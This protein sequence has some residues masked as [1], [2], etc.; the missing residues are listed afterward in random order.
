[1]LLTPLLCLHLAAQVPTWFQ[2][3]VVLQPDTAQVEIIQNI[4]Y[5]GRPDLHVG[6]DVYRPKAARLA[7]AVLLVHG[8]PTGSIPAEPRT[9]GQSTSLGRV[10]A[11]RGL[12]A[13]TFSHRLSTA[14]A[15]DT[16]AGDIRDAT[17]YVI[18][19][20]QTL[21][22]DASRLCVWAISAAGA[23][24]APTMREF[25]DRVRCLVSYY[26]VLSPSLLQDLVGAGERIPQTTP[27]LSDLMS[28]DSLQLPA[29]FV[30]RAGKDDARLNAGIDAFVALAVQRGVELE[31][32]TYPEGHHAFDILDD[33]ETSRRLLL[34]TVEFLRAHLLTN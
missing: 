4:D 24:I 25:H 8:G 6:M 12:V 1:M 33:T 22:V 26:N 14:N 19:H 29:T 32:H 30:M 21:G 20:A 18:S 13:I 17:A 3:P 28:R 5:K 9:A 31:F 27:S 34:Q 7:P 2:R 16:S 10:L 23:L 15:I 11:S